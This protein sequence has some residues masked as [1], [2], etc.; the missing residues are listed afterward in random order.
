MFNVDLKWHLDKERINYICKEY[1]GIEDDYI[2]SNLDFIY[3]VIK[4][5]YSIIDKY[6][7]DKRNIQYIFECDYEEGRAGENTNFIENV[8]GIVVYEAK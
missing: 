1:L 6:K 2:L 7:N 5:V 8:N 4:S 3:D